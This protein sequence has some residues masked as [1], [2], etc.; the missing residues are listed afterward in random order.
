MTKV[1]HYAN[2]NILD[3]QSKNKTLYHE[4]IVTNISLQNEIIIEKVEQLGT[5]IDLWVWNNNRKSWTARFT[6]GSLSIKG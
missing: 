5:L 6:I 4:I 2:S 3:V 1:L